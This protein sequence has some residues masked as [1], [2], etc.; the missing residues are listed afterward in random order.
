MPGTFGNNGRNTLSGPP[1]T[2]LNASLSKTFKMTSW[3]SL[4][5]RADSTNVLNHP[6]FGI[7]DTNFD[8]PVDLVS[9]PGRP[10]GPGQYRAPR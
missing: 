6:S 7:P 9:V 10:S 4:Q 3:T 2:V 8:D 5:V 1:L